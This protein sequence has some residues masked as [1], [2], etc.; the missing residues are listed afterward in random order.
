MFFI[1]NQI[2]HLKINQI[3]NQ[4]LT[5]NIDFSPNVQLFSLKKWMWLYSRK[6]TLKEWMRLYSWRHPLKE[7]IWLYSW[8]HTLNQ[9]MWL[10]SWRHT[11]KRWMWLY[12]C[13]HPL[14][15]WMWLYS[16]RQ[17]LKEWMWLYSWRHTLMEWMWLYSCRQTLKE[18]M[19]PQ[20][21]L[22]PPPPSLCGWGRGVQAVYVFWVARGGGWVGGLMGKPVLGQ[23]QANLGEH[24]N[25]PRGWGKTDF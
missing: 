15:E 22:H 6:Q 18:W 17:T 9:W 8:R 1:R 21:F 24:E 16:W 12:S 2:Y 25:K 23:R 4:L 13:R 3:K 14:K 7:W 20:C 11:L 10:Y 5:K 19:S